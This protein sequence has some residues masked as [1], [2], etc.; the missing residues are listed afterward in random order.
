MKAPLLKQTEREI[1]HRAPTSL[2]AAILD[3]RLAWAE[4]K[5]VINN[6]LIK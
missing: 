6:K 2:D 4:I 5:R 1:L 3:A